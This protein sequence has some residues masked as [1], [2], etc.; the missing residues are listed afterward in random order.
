MKRSLHA[1]LRRSAAVLDFVN[2]ERA[3]AE[4]VWRGRTMGAWRNLSPSYILD[5]AKLR[6]SLR[7]QSGNLSFRV[8]TARF[9]PR[10]AEVLLPEIFGRADRTITL[11]WK[12]GDSNS[13]AANAVR[14]QDALTRWLKCHWPGCLV[15]SISHRSDRAN[16]LSNSYLRVHVRARERNR[17]VLAASDISSSGRDYGAA[18]SQAFIW[19]ALLRARRRLPD[20]PQ[21][22]LVVP[23]EFSDLLLHRAGLVDPHKVDI[24]IWQIK[25][26]LEEGIKI[27]HADAPAPPEENRDFRWPVLGPF[28]WNPSLA[29]VLD[30]APTHIK[31]YPRFQD[32]D[33]LRLW[34]LEFARAQGEERDTI[35]FGV[36]SNTTELSEGNFESLRA[37]VETILYYRR[38]DSPN[39]QHPFYRLQAERWLESLILEDI[40]RLFPEL[41]PESV[42][43]QIPVYL[44]KDPGRVDI[45]GADKEGT[46]V[47][48]ELKIVPDPDLPL[49][50]LD[51]WGRVVRHSEDG[52]FRRRGYF[53]EV[54]LSGEPP[55]IYLVSPV[56]SFHNSTEQIV[57]YF[58]SRVE[59][60][61][62]AINEDW[63]SGVRILRRTRVRRGD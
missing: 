6:L 49:Q 50:A 35:S 45:L 52:D 34:G 8:S 2:A 51:Y 17:L 59:V 4:V 14:L 11:V 61:K 21:V 46:L 18:L 23:P 31:R 10:G 20:T 3:D 1:H 40:P 53:S 44:G 58:D 28:H 63:R 29:R 38:P 5:P 62:I 56:F 24:K 48:L 41:I 37:L 47:I 39:Q 9:T 13:G 32:Y 36:G 26:S 43:P 12:E 16:T 22:H 7:T 60:W 30:L 54:H 27:R 25:S 55:H 33:S 57:G 19:A 42:Y 15:L